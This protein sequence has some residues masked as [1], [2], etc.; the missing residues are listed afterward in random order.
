VS[1]DTDAKPLWKSFDGGFF[2]SN[3]SWA[4]SWRWVFTALHN[5]GNRN[6]TEAE[7]FDSRI[8]AAINPEKVDRDVLFVAR[9]V[10]FRP[11]DARRV[12]FRISWDETFR[13]TARDTEPLIDEV[14]VASLKGVEIRYLSFGVPH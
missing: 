10:L 3:H 7:H 4:A 12:V 5:L 9:D 1:P 14:V 2:G 11:S 6:K 8:F 13:R